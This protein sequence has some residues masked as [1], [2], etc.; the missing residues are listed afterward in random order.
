MG[1]TITM[2]DPHRVMVEGPTL[3][4]GI[5]LESPD[6]RAGMALVVAG[7]CADG[8]TTIEHTEVIER[9]YENVAERLTS[10][11]ALIEG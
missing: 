9:G 1:A 7:L 5:H 2:C 6:I 8:V 3:L 10:I 4:R 11:G